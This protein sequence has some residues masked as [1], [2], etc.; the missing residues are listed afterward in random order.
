[1]APPSGIVAGDV[2]GDLGHGVRRDRAHRQLLLRTLPCGERPSG[3]GAAGPC[4]A[5]PVGQGWPDGGV[6]GRDPADAAT[7]SSVC[8]ALY[9]VRSR[10]PAVSYPHNLQAARVLMWRRMSGS[11]WFPLFEVL[12][13]LTTTVA[14]AVTG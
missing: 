1:M 14:I 12:A 13:F 2:H 3:P 5:E 10:L 11:T 4:G 7:A 9:F 6:Q 8:R